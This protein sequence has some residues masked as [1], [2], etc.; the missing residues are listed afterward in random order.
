MVQREVVAPGLLSNSLSLQPRR[1]RQ[2][3][4]DR[5]RLRT[6]CPA[7]PQLQSSFLLSR[8]LAGKGAEPERRGGGSAEETNLAVR[9]EGKT[10]TAQK[11][12]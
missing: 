2:G 10:G 12:D 4:R 9:L 3:P 1:A 11:L 8:R 6:D 7:D 5:S